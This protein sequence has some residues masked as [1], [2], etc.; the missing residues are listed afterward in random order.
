MENRHCVSSYRLRQHLGPINLTVRGPDGNK[1][2]FT[3]GE[4]A[5]EPLLSMSM[6]NLPGKE[7]PDNSD[8][9]PLY[10]AITRIASYAG[11][12]HVKTREFD[13]QGRHRYLDVVRALRIVRDTGDAGSVSIEY[14]GSQGNAWLNTRRTKEL[15]EEAFGR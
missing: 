2:S 12:V 8:R 6:A 1:A 3:W 5:V 11:L 13:E 10:D 9:A 14:E 7:A 15:V 4:P